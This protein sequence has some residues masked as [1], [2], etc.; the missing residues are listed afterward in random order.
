M[1][2][3]DAEERAAW[4]LLV[5]AVGRMY[6]Y[7][8]REHREPIDMERVGVLMDIDGQA[9]ALLR[10]KFGQNL[11]TIFDKAERLYDDAQTKAQAKATA[12]KTLHAEFERLMAEAKEAKK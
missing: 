9:R 2:K 6:S 3:I 8:H 4:A 11:D 1:S 5:L 7:T 10:D 12:E